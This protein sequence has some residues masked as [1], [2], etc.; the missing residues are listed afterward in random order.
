[1]QA[2]QASD[3]IPATTNAEGVEIPAV[4]AV[5]AVAEQHFYKAGT[6][7][8]VPACSDYQSSENDRV[9]AA[10]G[11][12]SNGSVGYYTTDP[13]AASDPYH[14]K[15]CNEGCSMCEGTGPNHC[16]DCFDEGW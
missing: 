4:P 16:T 7:T 5:A 9:R 13:A 6:S 11:E 14:C 3:A 12:G 2:V 1:M 10:E 8:C 15:P